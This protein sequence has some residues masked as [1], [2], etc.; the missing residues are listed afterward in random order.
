MAARL[1]GFQ[2]RPGTARE[3]V[4]P[5]GEVISY[6]QYRRR[7]VETP[8]GVR[9]LGPVELANV[10]RKRQ[11]FKNIIDQI[12]KVR[13]AA[14]DQRIEI[15]EE[16]G[17]E[18]EAEDLRAER[19]TVRREAIKSPTRKAALKELKRYGHAR[20]AEGQARAK[21]ALTALGRREGIPDWVPVGASDRYRAGQLRRPRRPARPRNARS[22]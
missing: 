13:T 18:E 12:A 11:A 21:E 15:A 6:R 4:T 3:Y 9:P 16:L 10:R 2:R 7:L 5:E 8:G 20:D 19:R 22:R 14:I 17:D 1:A